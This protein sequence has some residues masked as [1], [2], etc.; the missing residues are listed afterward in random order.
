[1]SKRP[2]I[3]PVADTPQ[4]AS[5]INANLDRIE[6]AF[7][8]T[9]SRDGSTPNQMEADID[10][11]S[12]DL[13][14]VK[15]LN[16]TNLIIAGTNLNSEVSA[17][18]TS[19]TNAATSA[20]SSSS[21]ADRAEA[22][23]S[24]VDSVYST[25]ALLLAYT[26]ASRGVGAIWEA[27][28][29]RY[30]E[31]AASGTLG[32]A[33]AGGVEL[34]IINITGPISPEAFNA[35][36][37][38]TA[39]D[40]VIFEA[41]RDAF[42]RRVIRADGTYA[43][44][45]VLLNT[46]SLTGNGKLTAIAGASYV[47][48]LGHDSTNGW[49]YCRVSDVYIDGNAKASDGIS[50]GRS[51]TNDELAGRWIIDGAYIRNADKGIIKP[52]GNI[53]NIIRGTSVKACDFGYHA[54]SQASPGMHAGLDLIQG[55]EWSGNSLAAFYI[56]SSL[57]GTGGTELNG[58]VIE[59]NAGFGIFVKEWASSVVPLI[60]RN[61][62]LEG[63]AS[64][65]LVTIDA[66]VYTPRD[67][68]MKD[69]AAALIIGSQMREVEFDNARVVLDVCF[70]DDQT[71][72]TISNGSY[73]R[74]T[75]AITDSLK[76]QDIVVESLLRAN[77]VSGTLANSFRCLPRNAISAALPD[78]GAK[79]GSVSFAGRST[80]SIGGTSTLTSTQEIDGLLYD[81]C[82]EFTQPTAHTL[83]L[84]LGSITSGKWC[85]YTFD[86]KQISGAVADID[87][88][89]GTT[90]AKDFQLLIKTG[91][92]R[93]LGGVARAGSTGTI[94]L[95]IKNTSGSNQVFRISAVQVVEFDTEEEAIHYFNSGMYHNDSI[96]EN[97]GQTTDTTSGSGDLTISHGLSKTPLHIS[98]AM[99]TNSGYDAKIT[100]IT[101][102]TFDLKVVDEITGANITATSVTVLWSARA[103]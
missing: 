71:N 4:N 5:A 57:I 68:Y 59:T 80:Y 38:G 14:N 63:N 78:T 69:T 13:L 55:G 42:G 18:A 3:T 41:V 21:S 82:S 93:T 54:T 56:N 64:A 76:G 12:N 20:T 62:W 65:G 27:G 95:T 11:N 79:L 60:L 88:A 48:R 73:V 8:N 81:R 1:L 25:V 52:F 29:F 97:F 77:R 86:W 47:I 39:D 9:I 51:G 58:C 23:A 30:I 83:S 44:G 53:G 15:D 7:D 98:A 40:T 99:L 34:D 33:T 2:I 61:V 35:I 84:G 94:A 70:F 103:E 45:D 26:E 85:A 43:I 91:E 16:A 92:W 96:L 67:I 50:F 10:L 36:A 49:R 31:V 101:S 46:T 87:I 17:A 37:D 72:F 19:A 24:G 89:S 22:S 74:V 100:A 6:V 28:G 90:L 102:T 75:N 32:Q 66:V